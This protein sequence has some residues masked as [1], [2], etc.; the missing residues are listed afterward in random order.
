MK[1][2]INFDLLDNAITKM[3]A[4]PI[5]FTPKNT[6]IGDIGIELGSTSG[7]KID[8]NDI[9]V[10]LDGGGIFEYQGRQVLL[11]IPNQFNRLDEILSN[12]M[13]GNRFHVSDCNKIQEMKQR[14]KYNKYSVT[15][16][17]SGKFEIYNYQNP[18]QKEVSKL[19]I[20]KYCLEKLN[21][22]NYKN[23]KYNKKQEIFENFD[24]GEFFERYSTL[25]EYLP[26][27]NKKKGASTY[28][29][30][31][32]TLSRDYRASKNYICET[33]DTSFIKDKYLLHTHH[34]NGIKDDN[35]QNNLKAVCIDCHRK[36]PNHRHV[37]M[38][39]DQ[40]QKIYITRR[41]QNK[42]N[43]KSWDD[44][45]K[46]SDLSLHGYIDL[47]RSNQKTS[48]PDVGYVIEVNNQK[49]ALDLVW[50]NKYKKS[51]VATEYSYNF[52]MLKDWNILSLGDALIKYTQKQNQIII[53]ENTKIKETAQ[54]ALE[55]E[56]MIKYTTQIETIL[57]S[58]GASARGLHGKVTK[59]QK[60]LSKDVI[61]RL[62]RIATI[63]N[64][65]MHQ[66]GFNNYVFKDFEED[67]I[68]VLKYLKQLSI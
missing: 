33:C 41:E 4:E 54:S 37:Y 18:E 21:Y 44:V 19:H 30:N 8:I 52:F 12:P 65:K 20:C 9:E 36:E 53:E 55:L 63:R 68:I 17:L 26:N 3:G 15:N 32:E 46:Y 60:K 42:V 22:K 64:K 59:V 38:K 50:Q 62:R 34:I 57:E 40:L 45:F 24:I 16:N 7:K 28:T 14:N 6:P 11:F 67:S 29:D 31:W 23:E 47:L 58:M 51:A 1:L 27:I 5:V 35:N 56:A 61:F 13:I 10:N 2:N 66:T 25:F 43:I 48:L 39:Y 49:I